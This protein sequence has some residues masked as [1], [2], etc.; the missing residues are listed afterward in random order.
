[1]LPMSMLYNIGR[2]EKTMC[3]QACRICNI[4]T[5]HDATPSEN[6]YTQARAS[7]YVQTSR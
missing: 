7:L 5:K 3:A 4:E 6:T 1:M 2:I